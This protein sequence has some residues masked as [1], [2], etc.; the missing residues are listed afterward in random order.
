[1]IVMTDQWIAISRWDPL[2]ISFTYFSLVFCFILYIVPQREI[3]SVRHWTDT[4]TPDL[5]PWSHPW[6][7]QVVG[8]GTTQI[9][10]LK[11]IR[12]TS[13]LPES[14]RS[15]STLGIINHT[16]EIK[17][18]YQK[19]CTH[20]FCEGF[21]DL[22]FTW[23]SNSKPKPNTQKSTCSWVVRPNI[24]V[25]SMFLKRTWDG[26]GAFIMAYDISTSPKNWYAT[27]MFYHGGSFLFMIMRSTRCL[28]PLR[29]HVLCP[30]LR[31][32][33]FSLWQLVG[34]REFCWSSN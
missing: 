30:N 25:W 21:S 29:K 13:D 23:V 19:F 2:N 22:N 27:F 7:G 8:N 12:V 31:R 32:S 28:A 9:I 15:N 3:S 4:Y 6:L 33:W 5:L 11:I 18:I 16:L 1:M 20:D 34:S 14:W 10:Q 17:G 26:H 24:W